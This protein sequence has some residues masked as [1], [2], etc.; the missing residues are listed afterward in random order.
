MAAAALR[1]GPARSLR[2]CGAMEVNNLPFPAALGDDK[3]D[4][5]WIAERHSVTHTRRCIRAVRLARNRA[6]V[7][8]ASVRCRPQGPAAQADEGEKAEHLKAAAD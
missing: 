5:A 8:S 7:V 3:R 6:S 2:H 4:A 1:I